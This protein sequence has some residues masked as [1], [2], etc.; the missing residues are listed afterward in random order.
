MTHLHCG[1]CV[2]ASTAHHPAGGRTRFEEPTNHEGT[3]LALLVGERDVLSGT[4]AG[5]SSTMALGTPWSRMR[6]MASSLLIRVPSVMVQ[7][8]RVGILGHVGRG[9][10]GRTDVLRHW[11]V[12][13]RVRV[14]CGRISYRAT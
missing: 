10:R 3:G 11:E 5:N 12:G 2:W 14:L 8:V 4:A 1:T 6:A 9:H 7:S 13:P